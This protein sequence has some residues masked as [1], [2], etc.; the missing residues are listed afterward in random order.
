VPFTQY[1]IGKQTHVMPPKYLREARTEQARTY[2]LG[3]L[4]TVGTHR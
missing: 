4:T 1:L 2:D 3:C